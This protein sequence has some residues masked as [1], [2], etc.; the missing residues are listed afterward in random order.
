MTAASNRRVRIFAGVA[1]LLIAVAGVLLASEGKQANTGID[2]SQ[3]GNDS[4]KSATDGNSIWVRTIA[5][6]SI[7]APAVFSSFRGTVQSRRESVQAFRRGGRV[8][9]IRFHE[10]DRVS[11]GDVL[12]V[13]ETSDVVA[14][15]NRLKSELA[16]SKALLAEAVAGP[17]TQTIIAS[18]AEIRRLQADLELAIAEMIREESL[19]SRDAGSSR[20]YDLAKFTVGRLKASIEAAESRHAE[21]LEGTRPEVLDARRAAVAIAEAALERNGVDFD[22][23]RVIAPFDGLVTER[24]VDEGAVVNSGAAIL[25]LIEAPPF[26][27]RFALPNHV[28]QQF[29]M[30]EKVQVQGGS[31]SNSGS[32]QVYEG[33][34]LR[35]HP[36]L[37]LQTRT[38]NVD[39]SLLPEAPLVVGESVTLRVRE[40][41]QIDGAAECFWVPTESLV[42]SSRGLW[43]LMVA[44]DQGDRSLIERR[45][46]QVMRT[47]GTL[48]EVSGMLKQHDQI[49]AEGVHRVGP[50]VHVIFDREIAMREN[51][52]AEIRDEP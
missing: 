47:E 9:S 35:I 11:R 28:A 36:T 46:V 17:R 50:G 20:S 24:L 43:S 32:A 51:V 1:L 33:V 31:E 6:G 22:H 12:A 5:A 39:V 27:A 44:V 48:S 15:R 16:S 19:K 45:D 8:D 4:S 21:L 30:G 10:G 14:D 42:R 34:I 29:S 3:R 40:R 23:A 13:L 25:H 52:T 38:R 37:S 18:S 26:E 7:K 41:L 49:V 2:S